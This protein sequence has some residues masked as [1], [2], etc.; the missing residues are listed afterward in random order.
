METFVNTIIGMYLTLGSVIIA[1][2]LNMVFV[3]TKLYK[4]NAFPIDSG[5][6]LSDGKRIL[7][8]NKTIIGF[9]SMIVFN[10][11]AQ[12]ICGL[13]YTNNTLNYELEIYYILNNTIL[14]NIII[15][16]LFGLAYM[17]FELPN[18]FIK[19]RLNIKSG[20]TDKGIKGVIFLI[21]DQI[22]S[23]IG[24]VIVLNIISNISVIKSIAYI[25]LGAFTHISVN[26][27][28]YKLKIR[29]NL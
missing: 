25:A 24:V 22:D 20:K 11:L 29:K 10:I 18:S 26:F 4:N 9:I 13:I 17:I 5:R 3:K 21:I 7:G 8:D 1:G 6:Y 28:L 2:I 27:I 19:R 23:L 15:G 14:N 12:V 16:F